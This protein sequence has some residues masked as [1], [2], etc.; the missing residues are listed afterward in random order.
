M[1]MIEKIFLNF[2]EKIHLKKLADIYRKNITVMR[3]LILGVLTTVI[4][5][6]IFAICFKVLKVPNIPSN[7]IAWIG[8][9]MFAYIT[10]RK[11][12]FNSKATNIKEILREIVT[13]FASRLLTLGVDLVI[14]HVTVTVWNLN[15][16]IMKILA[17]IIVIIL[18]FI[19]SKL[20]VFR[21]KK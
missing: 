10:N 12:V 13:F 11:A 21:K 19:L 3:Y 14:M 16:M 6:A 15:E 5:I 7:I 1:K 2:L 8:A 9:V 17:N 20:I 18:N 4:N